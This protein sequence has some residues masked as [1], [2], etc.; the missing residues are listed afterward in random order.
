MNLKEGGKR[1]I[2]RLSQMWKCKVPSHLK[3]DPQ[4]LQRGND[5]R[6]QE[7]TQICQIGMIL[8]HRPAF[9]CVEPI[10]NKRGKNELL[11]KGCWI[12]L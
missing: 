10:Y 5:L 4:S 6:P 2:A 7:K 3:F 12:R 8:E 11:N 1:D 9:D